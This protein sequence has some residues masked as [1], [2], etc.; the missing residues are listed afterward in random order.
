M[1]DPI[2]GGTQPAEVWD[3]RSMRRLSVFPGRNDID[4]V[5]FIPRSRTLV[6]A[7]RTKPRIW[8]LDPPS[9][10]DALRG[11]TDEAWSAAFSPDGKLLATGSDDTDEHETIKLWDPASGRQLAGWNAH[12]A[13]VASL[14]FSPDGR[15]LASSSLDSGT[16][17]NANVKI[18]E[19]AS[20]IAAGDPLG[21]PRLGSLAGVQ[22]RRQTAGHR[23]R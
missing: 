13:T 12:T 15:F 20:A 14:A 4:N 17:E 16:P 9:S 19:V 5:P 22:P 2:P 6:V 1:I 7:G 18:W 21:P 11:H 10:P 23:R 8:R 3:L